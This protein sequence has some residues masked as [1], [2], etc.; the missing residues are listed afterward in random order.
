MQT[1][2]KTIKKPNKHSK[3]KQNRGKKEPKPTKNKNKART[4]AFPIVKTQ[5]AKSKAEEKKQNT[6]TAHTLTTH[7]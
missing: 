5:P 1:L 6:K 2:N 7:L 4:H 3:I